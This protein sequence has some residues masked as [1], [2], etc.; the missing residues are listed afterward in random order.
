MRGVTPKGGGM[1]DDRSQFEGL[2]DAIGEHIDGGDVDTV[3]SA[4]TFLLIASSVAG[5]LPVQSV[6][7]YV[8]SVA[9]RMYADHDPTNEVIH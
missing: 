8:N 1:N 3:V 9:L 7:Q 4:L 6:L 5:G 2:I